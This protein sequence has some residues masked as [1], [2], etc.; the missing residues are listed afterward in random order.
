MSSFLVQL[1]RNST[2]LP[3]DLAAA[4]LAGDTPPTEEIVVAA[5]IIGCMDAHAVVVGDP[6]S[7]W[8]EKRLARMALAV[9]FLVAMAIEKAHPD[10]SLTHPEVRHGDLEIQRANCYPPC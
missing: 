4:I 3:D 2:L 5:L 10:P 6:K 1:A 7:S 9:A 8:N